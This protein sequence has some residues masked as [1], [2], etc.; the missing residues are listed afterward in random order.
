MSL[1][2][3]DLSRLSLYQ[4]ILLSTDGTVTDL[5]S[6]VTGKPVHVTKVDQAFVRGGDD[7]GPG[8]GERDLL[9]VGSAEQLLRREIL[10]ST[11]EGQHTHHH[12]HAKSWFVVS[13][14]TPDMQRQLLE[15]DTPIGLLWQQARMETFREIVDYQESRE[16]TL[17]PYFSG[18]E[19][20]DDHF[21]GRRYLVFYRQQPLALI[22]EKF[23]A[24][25][26]TGNP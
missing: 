22:V 2:P 15:S 6:L 9:R 24:G 12:I 21:L 4:R 17:A 3:S 10:L 1:S 5:V 18:G 25:F 23:P 13:R 14:M 19:A 20:G 8:A 26:F 11:T 16:P 7:A